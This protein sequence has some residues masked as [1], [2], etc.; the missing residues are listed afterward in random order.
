MQAHVEVPGD[1]EVVLATIEHDC[2][3]GASDVGFWVYQTPQVRQYWDI[4]I[5]FPQAS[6]DHN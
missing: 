2:E 6:F 4:G 1:Q 3:T 5:R